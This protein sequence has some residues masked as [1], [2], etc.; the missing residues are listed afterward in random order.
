[1]K[2][3]AISVTASEKEISPAP[4]FCDYFMLVD[5]KN[6]EIKN[7]CKVRNP[8][9][10]TPESPQL[11]DFIKEQKARILITGKLNTDTIKA[12]EENQISV[13]ANNAGEAMQIIKEY[14]AKE[15][16]KNEISN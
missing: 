15:G 12:F 2:R 5:F 3:I 8:Y 1:M 13:S 9:K 14:I 4:E 10:N 6:K 16:V 7:V 11:I